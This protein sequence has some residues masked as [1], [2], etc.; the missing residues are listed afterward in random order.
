MGLVHMLSNLSDPG[1]MG[2]MIAA[3][4]IATLY[5]VSSANLIFL[6]IAQ[7]L[8]TRTQEEVATYEMM[9]E[10]ILAMQAGDNPRIVEAKM[11]AF[12]PPKL[13]ATMAMG[14]A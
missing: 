1:A 12:C 14:E 9:I 6:P 7:K 10:G 13:R 3:A 2:P 8:K 5:G 11:I 4:F